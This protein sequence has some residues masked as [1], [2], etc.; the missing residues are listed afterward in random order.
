MLLV[1]PEADLRRLETAISIAARAA[2]DLRGRPVNLST[3]EGR[4]LK[5]AACQ[6]IGM[7]TG[8]VIW[9]GDE[10]LRIP[11]VEPVRGYVQEES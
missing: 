3:M 7:A 5:S 4:A 9:P 6:A 1:I 10:A 2:V 11:R 8:E